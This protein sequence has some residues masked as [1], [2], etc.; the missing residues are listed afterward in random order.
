MERAITSG[1]LHRQPGRWLANGRRVVRHGGGAVGVRADFKMY[2]I[3]L[4]N[5]DHN[6]AAVRKLRAMILGK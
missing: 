2:M 4:H 5:Y 6:V 1:A 3:V